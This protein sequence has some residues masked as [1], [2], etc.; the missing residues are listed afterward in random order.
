MAVWPYLLAKE[1]NLLPTRVRNTPFKY[2]YRRAA[3]GSSHRRHRPGERQDPGHLRRLH[4][5]EVTRQCVSASMRQ[6]GTAAKRKPRPQSRFS[7]LSQPS[8]VRSSA[9]HSVNVGMAYDILQ[10]VSLYSFLYSAAK[11]HSFPDIIAP[12]SLPMSIKSFFLEKN[13]ILPC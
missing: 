12:T 6:N 7:Y 4:H 8:F 9:R 2:K 10:S 5:Q 13:K 11:I 3:G 1:T